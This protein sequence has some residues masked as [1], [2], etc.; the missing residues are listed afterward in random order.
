M[1]VSDDAIPWDDVFDRVLGNTDEATAGVPLPETG[2]EDWR[3]RKFSAM[4]ILPF[5][6]F[7]PPV[8]PSSTSLCRAASAATVKGGLYGT[9]S[10]TVVAVWSHGLV[11]IKERLWDA[12]Q[13]CSH[14]ETTFHLSQPVT[15]V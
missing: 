8:P 2:V 12:D 6:N 14:G 1:R 3:E 7:A 10:Q 11:E 4:R 5:W 13:R 9:V 15:V